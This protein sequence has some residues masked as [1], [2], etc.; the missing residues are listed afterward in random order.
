VIRIWD[1]ATG[2]QRVALNCQQGRLLGFQWSPDNQR[3]LTASVTTQVE[4][5]EK[6]KKPAKLQGSICIWEAKSGEKLHSI[7]NDS[8]W[9]T[10]AADARSVAIQQQSGE[11]R[12][13]D[14]VTAKTMCSFKA[15]SQS[16]NGTSAALLF[17]PDGKGLIEFDTTGELPPRLWDFATGKESR[18]FPSNYHGAQRPQGF[19]PDGKMVL[20]LAGGWDRNSSVLFW[21]V[22][23]GEFFSRTP[24]HRDTVRAVCFSPRGRLMA[25][26]SDDKTVRLW[27]QITGKEI[28]CLEGHK[29]GITAICFDHDGKAIATS[30]EDGSTR[31]WDVDKRQELA[32]FDG[33]EG[34]AKCVAF[35]PDNKQLTAGGKSGEIKV[36]NLTGFKPDFA[37]STGQD[38]TVLALTSDGRDS[39]SLH[40]VTAT[41]YPRG[42]RLILSRVASAKQLV[43][44]KIYDDEPKNFRRARE[45]NTAAQSSGGAIIASSYSDV[46]F[47]NL[48]GPG[49]YTLKVWERESAQVLHAFTGWAQNTALA[50]SPSGRVVA[51]C[52]EDPMPRR[53]RTDDL[54]INLWDVLTGSPLRTIKSHFTTIACLAF[55]PDGKRLASG[56]ADHTILIWDNVAPASG[57]TNAPN[58]TAKQKQSW[59][60][61]LGGDA[62]LARNT[63]E[64]LV[65]RP[66][67]AVALF[68]DLIKPA[69]PVDRSPFPG[70]I[71]ALDSVQYSERQKASAVL[72]KYGE[73]AEQ[74][75]RRALAGNPPLERR[76]RLEVLLDKIDAAVASTEN[77][78]VTRAIR[79]LEWMD[80]DPAWRLLEA[81]S[82]GEPDARLTFLAKSALA[83]K[84]LPMAD[85]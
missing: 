40:G 15:V 30:S 13:I 56:S 82:K 24:G 6:D 43:N 47:T 59:W 28:A 34:G 29:A 4:Y 35:S 65:A 11:T 10:P 64:I 44:V 19:S 63:M 7:E 66:A 83:R 42:E 38:G 70:L 48:A 58:A 14:I 25:S 32:H 77:L 75:L 46:G 49:E 2:T 69:P 39:L 9:V 61:D 5:S 21:D 27:D 50:I 76:R 3:L 31:L 73:L 41:G 1:F 8:Y 37:F 54:N 53:T 62:P 80:S 51:A 23:Q 81:L 79:C 68:R 22:G 18:V 72:E 33:P 74:T 26:G 16:S 71:D 78:R 57:L 17:T 52:Y 55:S 60:N 85:K 67:D 36:W 12:V 20:V 84:V 45:C